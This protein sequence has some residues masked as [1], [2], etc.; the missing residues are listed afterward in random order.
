MGPCK[1]LSVY[2]IESQSDIWRICKM[3]L[4]MRGIEAKNIKCADCLLE[5]PY[6]KLKANRILA[7]PPFNM[8]EWGHEKIKDDA[9]KYGTPSSG[10]PGGNYAFLS[11]MIHHLHD[12]DGK[13]GLV[14]A[15]GSMS[16]KSFFFISDI[17]ATL[18]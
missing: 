17:V 16:A 11:H 7:N 18:Q 10:K 3:N 6:E 1:G 13:L 15:N 2:G 4:A 9:R 5:H 8:G 14:L 12:N